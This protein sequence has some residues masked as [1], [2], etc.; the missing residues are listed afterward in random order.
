MGGRWLEARELLGR[1]GDLEFSMLEDHTG[2]LADHTYATDFKPDQ[3]N[4]IIFKV[5]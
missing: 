2:E 1:L 3:P 4:A 5:I